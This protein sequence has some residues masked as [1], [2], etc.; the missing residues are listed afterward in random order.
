MGIG[1]VCSDHSV[2]DA[3]SLAGS[4]ESPKV[5]TIRCIHHRTDHVV[6]CVSIMDVVPAIGVR[7][8]ICAGGIPGLRT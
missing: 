7:R 8:R 3:T 5:D 2:S 6:T 1:D 4:S